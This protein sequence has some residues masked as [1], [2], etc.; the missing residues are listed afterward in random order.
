MSVSVE[1]AH[2]VE[3]LLF[4]IGESVYGAD[5]SQVRRI[6][7]PGPNPIS[8]PELGT[9]RRAHRA[10][11]FATPEGEAELLVDLVRGVVN[12][13]LEELRR[14][15]LVSQ[16]LSFAVGMWLGADRPIVLLDLPLMASVVPAGK[17]TTHVPDHP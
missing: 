9:P 3:L 4:E 6:D 12:V 13:S 5:A 16:G 2:Q 8:R 10:L 17:E 14:L 11:V 15:P 7:R 1:G